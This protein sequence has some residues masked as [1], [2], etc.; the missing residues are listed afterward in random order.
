M[1]PC[2]FKVDEGEE[3]S[4]MPWCQA[5]CLGNIMAMPQ[6]SHMLLAFVQLKGA[7]PRVHAMQTSQTSNPASLQGAATIYRVERDQHN[8]SRAMNSAR[9]CLPHHRY[10]HSNRCHANSSLQSPCLLHPCASS[11]FSAVISWHIQ[12]I[13]PMA[14]AGST[15]AMPPHNALGPAP[16]AAAA[17]GVL[18]AP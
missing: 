4:C 5:A 14:V 11:W 2:G 8:Y 18:H 17:A 16:L 6:Q 13:L 12:P 15:P 10:A 1:Q 7:R 9:F 3:R